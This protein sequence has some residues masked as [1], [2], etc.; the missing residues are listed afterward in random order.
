MRKDKLKRSLDKIENVIND[1]C[2]FLERMNFP[3]ISN[4]NNLNEAVATKSRGTVTTAMP[5]SAVIGRD[6]DCDKIAAMLHE[7]EEDAQA[8]RNSAQWY[9]VIGIHGIA[10]SG[11]TTLAQ[12]VCA[13]E[14]KNG[15]FDLIMWIHVSQNFRVDTIFKEMFEAAS[16]TSCPQFYNLDTLQ[17][18]L[19]KK[20]HG[21]RDRPREGNSPSGRT[22]N[23]TLD[24]HPTRPWRSPPPPRRPPPPRPPGCYFSAR[25]PRPRPTPPR[26]P[27][28]LSAAARPPPRPPPRSAAARAPAP[29]RGGPSPPP[30]QVATTSPAMTARASEDPAAQEEGGGAGTAGPGPDQGGPAI[31]SP[32]SRRPGGPRRRPR[33]GSST[34]SCASS[35]SPTAPSSP[36]AGS[37]ASSPRA[38]PPCDS[39]PPSADPPWGLCA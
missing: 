24:P 26:P 21:K 22:R 17:D 23:Q 3:S 29:A 28:P 33:L 37:R 20:L 12:L 34:S 13:R 6:K 38:L 18:N 31:G 19:V 15:N 27:P 8:D 30:T 2:Q 10:G 39:S 5:P 4:A 35:R 16:G 7:G 36:S 1:A 9:S 32:T 14:K 11:K 25:S